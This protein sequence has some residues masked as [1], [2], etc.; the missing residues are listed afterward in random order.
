MSILETA[1]QL[2]NGAVTSVDLTEQSLQKAE[3]LDTELHTF[4]SI[5]AEGARHQAERADQA[6]ARG[7]DRGLMHGIPIGIKDNLDT[8]GLRTTYGAASYRHHVPSNDAEVVNRLR[9]SG[10][11]SIGKQ[12]LH[13]FA[14]GV[15]SVNPHYGIVGNPRFPGKI[16]GGSSGG[17]AAAVAAGI[18][19]A[20]VGS[21]TSGSIRIPAACCGVVGFKPT[22]NAVPADGCFPEAASLD[23]V[24][25]IADCVADVSVFFEAMLPTVSAVGPLGSQ[26]M[27]I[28]VERD[29]FFADID[30]SIERVVAGFLDSIDS[31]WASVQDVTIPELEGATEALTVTDICETSALHRRTIEESPEVFGDDVRQLIMEGFS[32]SGV[33]YIEAQD[34]RTQ[35]AKTMAQRFTEFDVLVSPTLPIPVPDVDGTV[36]YRNGERVD[37]VSEMMRLIG[38]ANLLGLP[39][40]SI[41]I[42]T[43]DG[44]PVSLQVIGARGL[45]RKVLAVGRMLEQA[46]SFQPPAVATVDTT[47]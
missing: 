14:L 9:L 7:V 38:P 33:E 29:F 27:R 41:P 10:A 39:A 15:T 23:T 13:E 11:V 37:G 42:G 20:S 45:D 28:A 31:R 5:D 36:G 21:D 1:A 2:R 17:G 12:N 8:K 16:A 18:V 25:P 30:S 22:F 32:P 35:L 47:S 3:A 19:A 43:V 6:L 24:G 26:Q 4:I 44:L 40:L 34:F 46:A